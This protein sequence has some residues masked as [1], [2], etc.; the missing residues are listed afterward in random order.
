MTQ[1]R[2][3]QPAGDGAGG[4]AGPTDLDALMAQV[5]RGDEAAFA[6]VYDA[7]AGAVF[8]LVRQVLRNPAQSE[9]VTQE[10]LVEVWRSATRFDAD[11]GSALA[12]ILMLAHRR[13]VDRVRSE[14]ASQD[15]EDK[16]AAREHVR[17]L[18]D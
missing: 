8:G 4:P 10:V 1:P 11:R 18:D 17:P 7:V 13:A 14:Q 16:A 9:E 2:P 12:W 6:R 3:L 5:A 15:R